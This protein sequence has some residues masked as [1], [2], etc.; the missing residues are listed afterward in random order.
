MRPPEDFRPCSREAYGQFGS[1]SDQPPVDFE[2]PA[3]EH[4]RQIG[5]CRAWIRTILDVLVS[6]GQTFANARREGNLLSAT[7][8]YILTVW[9]A[10]ALTLLSTLSVKAVL[11]DPSPTGAQSLWG[12]QEFGLG[13]TLL[14]QWENES[15]GESL[16][17]GVIGLIVLPVSA[18]IGLAIHTAIVHLFL[19]LLGGA[20]APFETTFRALAYASGAV[21]VI[22]LV[23]CCGGL[24]ALL[25]LV[26]HC[27]VALMQMHLTDAWRAVMAVL[28]SLLL[29]FTCS[30]GLLAILGGFAHAY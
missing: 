27:S 4:W 19:M 10:A 16:I 3:W 28:L 5:L 22:G 17:T 9:I 20:K 14:T 21:T 26:V 29:I 7:M 25:A 18:P 30:C 1:T 2:G 11:G 12:W 8:F 24:F 15:F 23:P 6:P 13:D